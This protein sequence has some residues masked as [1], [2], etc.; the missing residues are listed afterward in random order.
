MEEAVDLQRTCAER[1]FLRLLPLLTFLTLTGARWQRFGDIQVDFGQELTVA[2]QLLEGKRLYLD[3]AYYRGPFSPY[4]NAMLMMLFGVSV[5]TIVLGNL[6]IGLAIGYGIRRLLQPISGLAIA[7]VVGSIFFLVFG[8]TVDS[9]VN[10]FNFVTPFVHELTHGIALSLLTVLALE[11]FAERQEWWTAAVGGSAYGLA[12][13]TR[14][15][16]VVAL[17]GAIGVWLWCMQQQG[18]L[19]HTRKTTAAIFF[20]VAAGII[21]AAVGALALTMP[22]S[23]ALRST[24]AS[25]V[26]TV[27]TPVAASPFIRSIGG[28]DM[29]VSTL[30]Y[31]LLGILFLILW[32]LCF[33]AAA[34]MF[35]RK[36]F[37]YAILFTIMG[38]ALIFAL[39]S[40]G[41]VPLMN[42]SILSASTMM[43]TGIAVQRIVVGKWQSAAGM[44]LT[45]TT[46]TFA[47]LMLGKIFLLPMVRFYGFA[48]AMPAYILLI[49]AL[50]TMLPRAM[51]KRW[52]HDG[53]TYFAIL[54]TLALLWDFGVKGVRDQR[55]AQRITIPVGN[56]ADRFH[57]IESQR[58]VPYAAA[59]KALPSLIPADASLA[60]IPE[61]AMM[62]FL[63]RRSLSVP[64]TNY[65]VTEYLIFGREKIESDLRAHPPDFILLTHKDTSEFGYPLFGKVPEYGSELMK[66][67]KGNY[68]E[69]AVYGRQPL[70][71]LNQEGVALWRRKEN[72]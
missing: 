10:C 7:S 11:R 64:Y 3:I 8:F 40:A 62:N 72:I 68:V 30:S 22:V 63:L 44:R 17:T 9:Y 15:E 61:G 4:F 60:A 39:S 24:F 29:P 33:V 50:F 35:R 38:Y 37:Y 52:G 46:G 32:A 71:K 36:S 12:V 48:H 27:T 13:L 51:E 28:W 21:A 25:I 45:A 54:V 14:L 69:I 58:N 18:G 70:E 49:A 57:I 53:S 6:L 31:Q 26:V 5:R 16:I 43:I 2:W 59:L 56:G 34:D 47:L 23:Q 1:W 19:L 55:T 20:C 42:G 41:F 67:I 65:M 66:W